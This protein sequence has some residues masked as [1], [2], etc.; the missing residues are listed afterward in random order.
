MNK[1]MGF[2]ELNDL[3]LPTVPW[4]AYTGA[5]T[6][7]AGLLW[8]VRSAVYKGDDLNLPR[9]VGVT[10]GEAT[11]FA[12]GLLRSLAQ[13]GIVVYYPYFLA[14]KSGTLEVRG[15]KVIIEAVK[16]DLWNLVSL[17]D[18][19]VTIE[20]QDGQTAFHG[21]SRFLTAPEIAKILE[22]VPKIRQAFRSQLIEGHSLLLEWSFAQT[23]NLQKE[24]TG[25]EYLVFYELRTV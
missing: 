9:K 14:N 5:E 25:S 4:K 20:I 17:S 10:A 16:A 3:N 7:D 1:L 8:T 18:R 22:N 2:F 15:Q 11:L 24:P 19:E 12:T 21:N 6:L 13:N 23:C